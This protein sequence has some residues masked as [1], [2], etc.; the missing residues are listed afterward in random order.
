MKNKSS[1]IS[2]S[3]KF[4]D[5]EAQKNIQN[6]GKQKG[7]KKKENQNLHEAMNQKKMF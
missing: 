6:P 4:L 2:S 1:L 5:K 3:C 7:K